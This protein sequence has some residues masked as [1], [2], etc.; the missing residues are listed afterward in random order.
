MK[1]ILSLTLAALMV[2]SALF[3]FAS[4]KDNGGSDLEYVKKKGKLVVGITDF[5]PMDYKDADGKW[6]GFDADAA[7]A[8]AAYIGVDV[9]FVEIDWDS[10]ELELNNKNIDCIWNGMTITDN[11][12]A[13]MSVSKPYFNN[14]QVVVLPAA[15]ADQFKT[16]EACKALKFAVEVGSAGKDAAAANGFTFTEVANQSTAVQEAAAGTSEACIIDFLM[17][18]TT[19]GEGKDFAQLTYTCSL[20]TEEYGVGFRT[21]SDLCDKLNTFFT[22]KAADVKAIAETYGIAEYLIVK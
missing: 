4:C 3:C 14:A 17:A 21:G 1:R 15:K 9:E 5:K 2:L 16:A 18:I 11:V 13:A 20:S 6:I 19:V 8:F 12:K 7:K 10:K 22:E